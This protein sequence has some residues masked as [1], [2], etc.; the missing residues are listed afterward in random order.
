LRVFGAGVINVLI[1]VDAAQGEN[2]MKIF[3]IEYETNN[4]TLHRTVK[5]AEAVPDSERFGSELILAKL[6]SSWPAARLVEIWNS[7]PGETPVK[8]FKDRATGVSRI[9]TALQSLGEVLPREATE[10]EVIHLVR[11]QPEAGAGAEPADVVPIESVAMPQGTE[12]PA[13]DSPG[14]NGT[15][16]V[17][18][19]SP[20][21]APAKASGRN[22]TTRK[23]KAS[24]AATT[25]AVA[26]REGSKTSRVIAMLKRQDGI[27]LE[28]IMTATGWQKHTTRAL[29][30]AGGSL[31]KKHGLVVTSEKAGDKRM[32]FIKG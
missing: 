5:E 18:P 3:T 32:Y 8:K 6:A 16:P 7:L 31:T 28:E 20:D 25:L 11:K 26:P 1:A 21:V 22:K 19:Q 23:D 17:A 15:A 13:S 10:L 2:T 24:V 14:E 29:L 12:P 27:T 4:I 30:S 9:W